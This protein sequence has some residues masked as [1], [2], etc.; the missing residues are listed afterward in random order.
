VSGRAQA[1][2]LL[3]VDLQGDFLERP[4][5]VPD[6]DTLCANAARLVEA[7]RQRGI[8]VVHAHTVVRADGSDRMPHWKRCGIWECVEGTRGVRPPPPLAPLPGELVLRKRY[9]S[10]F[11]DRRLDAW[12][13]EQGVSHLVV[14]GV[15]LHS[16][17]RATVLDAYER[18]HD[19]SVVDD[20]VG[21][22]EPL[23]AE[24][25]R[26]Y[27]ATRAAA[28]HCTDEIIL[29]L[30]GRAGA[31]APHAR[32][33][34]VA[35]IGGTP[36]PGDGRRQFIHDNPC[37]SGD[38]LAEVPLG[39]AVEIEAAAAAGEELR[40]PWARAAPVTRAERLERW[41]LELDARRD[42]LT[43]LIVREVAKPRR[44]ATEEVA[45]AVAHVR[46]AAGLARDPSRMTQPVA[47]GVSAT[48]RPLGIVGL[49]TPW[50][51]PLA[52]AVGKI[53][54]ALAFGNG[55]ILKPAPQAAAVALAILDSL[56]RCDVPPGVVNAVCGDAEAARALCH[57][58]RV[59]AI[60]VTGSWSTGRAVAA[61]C[62][63]ALKPL[64]AELG[65]NNAAIV[66]GD[67]DLEAV[68]PG[69]V[70]NAFCFAGQRCT[71]V[72][73]F[74][75]ERRVAARFEAL[76]REA[77]AALVNGE[78]DDPSTEVGPL[79]SVAKRDRVL[80]TVG[81]AIAAGARLVAGGDVPRGLAHGAWMAP[82]L[83]SDVNP[84]SQIA[85]EETFAPVAVVLPAAGVEEALAIANGVPQGLLLSVHTTDERARARVLEAAEAGIVQLTSGPLAV[86]PLAPFGGWKA[87]GL[88]PP[89]HG[90]WDAEFYGRVQAVYVDPTC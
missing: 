9:F 46:S 2:A 17:V 13:R 10:A 37:R 35:V 7:M 15:Y 24:L 4:G 49:V 21:S 82:T 84:R 18:G 44:F 52:I 38:V 6:R 14:A 65:G 33:L 85:Q 25:T 79:I 12:L 51:N 75:V 78:P 59:A 28:F 47:P 23:H 32:R 76:A 50:N 81:N 80:A 63:E 45:R 56:D 55:V 26:A 61:Y 62:A 70:R 86:H 43:D 88:G 71:A 90:I 74:I 1:T 42:L 53:A 67:A 64:Q 20:A 36:R 11:A 69:L 68:V 73:R 83:L 40:A 22:T 3:L 34:P 72:R 29:R 87:S 27:L 19:V 60:S 58:P 48:R 16:C 5:L 89:E 66:L 77:M 54:P 8:P 30:D 31:T 57:E 39:A 41:A